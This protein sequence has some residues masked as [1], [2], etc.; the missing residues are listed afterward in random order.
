MT[1]ESA[2]FDAT[3]SIIGTRLLISHYLLDD[4]RQAY[5]VQMTGGTSQIEALGLIRL[6][7]AQILSGNWQELEEKEDDE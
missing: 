2:S 5:A 1:D 3:T 4:G 6:A 7:E